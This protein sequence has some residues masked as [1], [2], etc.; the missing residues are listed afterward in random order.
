MP[1]ETDTSPDHHR[2]S[3]RCTKHK[4]K[5]IIYPTINCRI[6]NVRILRDAIPYVVCRLSVR[7]SARPLPFLFPIYLGGDTA[8]ELPAAEMLLGVSDVQIQSLIFPALRHG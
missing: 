7:L 3:K 2:M 1:F 5:K 4:Q 6:K 8:N